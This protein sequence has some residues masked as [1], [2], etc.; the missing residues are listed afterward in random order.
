ML[1]GPE[2]GRGRRGAHVSHGL[3]VA[4]G[5][6]D[7]KDSRPSLPRGIAD[8]MPSLAGSVGPTD[9]AYSCIFVA[10]S[11]AAIFLDRCTGYRIHT[12]ATTRTGGCQRMIL[13]TDALS[14]INNRRPTA[15]SLHC[16][17]CSINDMAWRTLPAASGFRHDNFSKLSDLKRSF[18]TP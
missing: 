4:R 15:A 18:P 7:S 11:L 3:G 13:I 8:A 2:I 1:P 12:V 17:S 14:S 6:G 5:T 10:F 16:H 9:A